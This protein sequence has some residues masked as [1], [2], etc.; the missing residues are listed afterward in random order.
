MADYDGMNFG[1]AVKTAMVPNP[2]E[3][4]LN[5]F[6][7]LSGVYRLWGGGRGRVFFV[8]GLLYGSTRA[9]VIAWRTLFLTYDDGIGR[10]LTD[11]DSTAWS[12]VVFTGV[13]EWTD[14][15]AFDGGGNWYRPYKAG[16]FGCL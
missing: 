15:W 9:S 8:E 4:Q 10:V 12:N 14:R 3:A 2:S 1:L 7:G 6:F 5:A 13:F 16:F 11:T